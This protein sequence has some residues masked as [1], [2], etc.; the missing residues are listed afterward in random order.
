LR[1]SK[2]SLVLL[3][4]LLCLCACQST[5]LQVRAPLEEEGEVLLY[6]QPFAQDA[7]RLRFQIESISARRSDGF[8]SPVSL[9]LAELRGREMTRQRLLGTAVVPPGSYTG[10]TLKIKEAILRTEDGEAALLVPDAPVRI[11]FPFTVSRK[12]SYVLW[13]LFRTS[14]SLRT[15]FSFTPVFS[16]AMPPRPIASLTG[17]ATNSGSNNI[18]VFDKRASQVAGAIATRGGPAGMALDQRGR[19]AYAALPGQ[20][21][22]EVIDV[23][24]GEVIDRMLL[25]AGDRP[26]E[27]ALTPD[28]RVLLSANTGSNTISVIETPTL[29]ESRRITVGNGPNSILMDPS[30]RRA[31]VFNSLASSISVVDIANKAIVTTISTDPGPL[32]GQFNK[33]GDR[34]YVIH[35]LSAYLSIIDARTLSTVKRVQVGMGMSYIKVDTVTDFVYMGRARDTTVG[36]YEPNSFVP[37]DYIQ[38]EGGTRYLTID[39]DEN[40]LVMVG[41]QLPRLTNANLISRK[42]LSALDIGDA[43]YWVTMMGER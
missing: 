8:E 20:D 4:G 27:L 25:S 24:V 18:T 32:R 31:Y 35:E 38:T 16:V 13:F 26:R 34:F 14:E 36:V 23:N 28:G 21:T 17:Y 10:F 7:D 11:D 5:F 15:G 29:F 6:L 43:P 3:C 30:G 12:K 1:F 40:N 2:T 42:R 22:I 37:M 19:R 33:R 39:G 9:R 41:A